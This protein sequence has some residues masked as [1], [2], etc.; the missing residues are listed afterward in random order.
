METHE[1]NSGAHR[2]EQIQKRLFVLCDGTRQ[3]GVN[4]TRP[5]T[6][7]ATLA[8]CLSP[9]DD[10]GCLQI[11][12]YDS[13]VGNG[14]SWPARLF[15][16]ATGK[17]ISAKIR[18]AYSFLSH[19][20]NFDRGWDETVLVGYSRGAFAVQCLAAFI[21]DAGLLKKEHLYYLRGLFTL[22]S[23]REMPGVAA[24]F[25]A[26]KEALQEEGLLHSIEINACAVW[27]TVSSL[28]IGIQIPPRQLSFVGKEVPKCV[29]NAFQALA[30]DESRRTFRPILWQE[31]AQNKARIH[32][33]WFL[34]SHSDVGGNGDAALGMMTF[35]WMVGMLRDKVRV[36]F[37]K[38]E[39]VRHLKHKFLEWD[40]KSRALPTE[41][42]F[43]VRLAMAKDKKSSKCLR[44]WSTVWTDSTDPVQAVVQWK[45]DTSTVLNEA[46]LDGTEHDL[47]RSWSHG[48][49]QLFHT[50]RD[51]FVQLQQL[52]Q[53]PETAPALDKFKDL[54]REKMQ[55]GDSGKLAEDILYK[56]E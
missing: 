24:K 37:I 43:T 50:D 31:A 48:E 52:V 16:G 35:L 17:G 25:Q 46:V 47:L 40:F 36:K 14:T 5:L 44:S 23:H 33:C 4:K 45:L 56:G 34:G 30:L 7:V 41:I 22:W 6:N 3:D 55:F 32:Q 8:R 28:G 11:V 12:Y 15:D 49:F 39:I 29:Q 27:D 26:E 20:Y 21:S 9:I 53:A 1:V 54:L 13:G 18:N 42:H 2:A 38:H 51:G 10:E 19:N